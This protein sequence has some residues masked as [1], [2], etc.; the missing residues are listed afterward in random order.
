MTSISFSQLLQKIFNDGKLANHN[1]EYFIQKYY[2]KDN[3]LESISHIAT[4]TDHKILN[5]IY[6]IS[7]RI[8]DNCE[9]GIRHFR[10]PQITS[11][12]NY[13]PLFAQLLFRNCIIN[14]PYAILDMQSR[15]SYDS[16]ISLDNNE[17]FAYQGYHIFI[18]A[19]KYKS[20][21]V[22]VELLCDETNKDGKNF[23]IRHTK[24]RC[25]NAKTDKDVDDIICE[26]K[27]IINK[28]LSSPQQIYDALKDINGNECTNKIYSYFQSYLFY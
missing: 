2:N 7:K 18:F 14:N 24:A 17:I 15:V 26:I 8:Q 22:M 16:L 5:R 25:Q 20:Y 4:I 11:I 21:D 23:W 1:D 27:Y 19:Q 28:D 6:N 12:C 10:H 13:E 9:C 3:I